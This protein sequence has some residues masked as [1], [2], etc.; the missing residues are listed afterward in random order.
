MMAHSFLSP[1]MLPVPSYLAINPNMMTCFPSN[2]FTNLPLSYVNAQRAH[3]D[4]GN[5]ALIG[6]DPRMVT[7]SSTTASSLGQA[8]NPIVLSPS[9]SSTTTSSTAANRRTSNSGSNRS[10]GQNPT[11]ALRRTYTGSNSSFQSSSIAPVAAAV[12]NVPKM[13]KKSLKRK[14]GRTLMTKERS[15]DDVCSICLSDFNNRKHTR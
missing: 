5:A 12:H 15:E 13:P 7:T 4:L 6:F 9:H 11:A 3:T 14:S 1:L 10:R 8:N 2:Q